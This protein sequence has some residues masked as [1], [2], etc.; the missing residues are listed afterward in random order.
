MAGQPVALA[1]LPLALIKLAFRKKK[2]SARKH[3]AYFNIFKWIWPKR[4]N[5]F[6][7]SNYVKQEKSSSQFLHL[8]ENSRFSTL[9]RRK[10]IE[11]L[12]WSNNLSLS[13]PYKFGSTLYEFDNNNRVFL[14]MK[15]LINLQRIDIYIVKQH[16]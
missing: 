8:L 7:P 5:N 10:N 2:K 11:D 12:K 4:L 6:D 9:I 1:P 14:L 16:I 3:K 13:R 15:I